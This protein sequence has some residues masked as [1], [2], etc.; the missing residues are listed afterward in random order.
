MCTH[1]VV[2]EMYCCISGKVRVSC[3]ATNQISLLSN[4]TL[5]VHGKD[6]DTICGCPKHNRKGLRGSA[7]HAMEATFEEHGCQ[8]VAIFG[9]LCTF[10]GYH[11]LSDGVDDSQPVLC[12]IILLLKVL[13]FPLFIIIV[14]VFLW[15]SKGHDAEHVG[16]NF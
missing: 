6:F 13:L 12:V 10:Q 8:L 4:I 9:A 7:G 15:E 5:T 1:S 16:T 14:L 3:C 2:F 11:H